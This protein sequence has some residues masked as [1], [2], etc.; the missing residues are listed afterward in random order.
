MNTGSD[1]LV[2]AAE[3]KL[4]GIDYSSYSTTGWVAT[5]NWLGTALM[6]IREKLV[7]IYLMYFGR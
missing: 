7:R 1:I 2:Y 4:L 3:E 6:N 5:E